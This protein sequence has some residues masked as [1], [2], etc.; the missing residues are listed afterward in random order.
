M[1]VL[2]IYDVIL[3]MAVTVFSIPGKVLSTKVSVLTTTSPSEK[4]AIIY[5]NREIVKTRAGH[6]TTLPR[7]CDNSAATMRPCFQA[8]KWLFIA[9]L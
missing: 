3:P 2:K 6:A 1:Y 7:Q 8:T 4:K 5:T 9:I